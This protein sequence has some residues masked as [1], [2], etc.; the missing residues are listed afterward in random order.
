MTSEVEN[1]VV[2]FFQSLGAEV[3]EQGEIV[4]VRLF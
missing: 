4:E 1:F 3:I 2:K